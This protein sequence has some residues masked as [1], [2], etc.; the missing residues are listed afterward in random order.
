M[1]SMSDYVG[2][3]ENFAELE[4][5]II[6]TTKINKVLKAI[7]KLDSIPLEPEFEFKKRSQSLLDKWNKLMASDGPATANGV[8]GASDG[9]TDEKKDAPNGVQDEEQQD[10]KKDG[11]ETTKDKDTSEEADSKID[12]T[13]KED[14]EKVS[15]KEAEIV[16]A[17]PANLESGVEV[18]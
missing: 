16:R 5:S 1:K 7:L 9:Q 10:A 4:V 17:I 11:D 2:M 8:N 15:S 3:L 14:D 6:R 13:E 18:R 12:T